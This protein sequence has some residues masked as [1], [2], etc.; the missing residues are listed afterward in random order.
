[1]DGGQVNKSGLV[2]SSLEAVVMKHVFRSMVLLTVAGCVLSA[3][4]PGV[5]A[6]GDVAELAR[7]QT[8]Y[9]D[10]LA[11]IERVQAGAVTARR[12]QY[13][14]ALLALE[15]RLQEAGKLEPLLAVQTERGRFAQQLDLADDDMAE[16][17]DELRSLQMA[18]L[19]WLK[20]LPLDRARRIVKLADMYDRSLNKLQERLTRQ[21]DLA[22][23]IEVKKERD[24][25]M[26]RPEV[27]ASRFALADAEANKPVPT[28]EPKLA[29]TPPP[30]PEK[31]EKPWPRQGGGRGPESGKARKALHQRFRGVYK[32]ILAQEWE[33]AAD[34][35]DPAL[36]RELGVARIR[37]R[38]IFLS[39][40]LKIA[41]D[42]KLK[43]QPGRVELAEDGERAKLFPKVRLGTEWVEQAPTHWLLVD[44]EWYIDLRPAPR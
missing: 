4:V 27:S 2:L 21:G 20:D 6:A 16:M 33:Q 12:S 15:R 30:E 5:A 31:P 17:P 18:Y 42:G 11:K 24:A 26:V 22:V 3:R 7:L 1:M 8:T 28:P 39:A 44:G 19:V 29:P 13:E 32:S 41:E 23:A 14:G 9:A 36:V 25:L 35:V 34:Y 10:E 43:L 40:V 38:L 37:P